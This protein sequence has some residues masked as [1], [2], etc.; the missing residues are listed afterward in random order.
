[1]ALPASGQ[2]SLSQVNTELG[3]GSTNLI[4]M[5]SAAVR[6]LFQVPTGQIEMSDGYGKSNVFTFAISTNQTNANLR[7][8]ALS[9]GWPGSSA[10]E[11]TINSGVV[12]SGSVQNNSTAALTIDGAWPA[13]ITLTNNGSIT[14]RGGNGGAG[15]FGGVNPSRTT[16]GSPGTTGGRALS[17]STAVT[18]NNG[19][20]VISGGGG[21]GGGGGGIVA[22]FSD[23]EG[24]FANYYTGGGG[25]GGGRS[26]NT[27]SSGGSAGGRDP[28]G[29]GS[30]LIS[31]GGGGAGTI[32]SAGGGGAG[33]R[34]G[35]PS[36]W[37]QAGAGGSGGAYGASG[38]AAGSGSTFNLG[39]S[40]SITIRGAGSGGGGGQAVSGNSNITWTAFGTRTGGIV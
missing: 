28:S 9:A 15:G 22:F 19:S 32:S 33:G 13:G 8:L 3:L 17:V 16:A 36:Q 40:W 2:I 35:F 34:N 1:M 10:V 11:A 37:A 12:I 20:G 24:S 30:I 27:N 23:P 29:P 7:S 14:A 18:I 21:G 5:G 38:S 26:S 6:G 4:S 25:G 31:T 39:P